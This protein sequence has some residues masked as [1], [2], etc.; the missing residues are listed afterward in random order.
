MAGNKVSG[1]LPAALTHLKQLRIL[2]LDSNLLSGSVPASYLQSPALWRI[3]LVRLQHCSAALL[4]STGLM[5]SYI[6]GHAGSC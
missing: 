2:L 6:P 5:L 3:N 1:V 4:D